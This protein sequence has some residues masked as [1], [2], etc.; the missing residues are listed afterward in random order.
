MCEKIRERSYFDVL[1]NIHEG[2]KNI[3]EALVNRNYNG[4]SSNAYNTVERY[5]SPVSGNR[6]TIVLPAFSG[7]SAS[8]RAAY[9]AAPEEIPTSNPSFCA[10]SRLVRMASS[11]ST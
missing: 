8:F 5:R 9:T 1:I 3:Y 4:Y 6:A 10:S 2:V 7:S 11:F